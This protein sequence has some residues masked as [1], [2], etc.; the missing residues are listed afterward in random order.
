MVS[1]GVAAWNTR[2]PSGGGDENNLWM[3]AKKAVPVRSSVKLHTDAEI[4]AW[5]AGVQDT[6]DHVAE[7][8]NASV[9]Q[10]AEASGLNPDQVSVRPGPLVPDHSLS[11]AGCARQYPHTEENCPGHVSDAKVCCRCG[12]HIDSL[13]PA[14]KED[15][16]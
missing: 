2:A 7:I 14:Q 9:A 6:L 10:P 15:R 1:G 3:L 13:R 12:T 16:E 8:Y 11:Q 5:G 4:A